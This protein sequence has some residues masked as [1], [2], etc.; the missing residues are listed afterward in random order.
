M[1]LDSTT[2]EVADNFIKVYSSIEGSFYVFAPNG[3]DGWIHQKRTAPRNVEI[4]IYEG[5]TTKDVNRHHY[6]GIKVAVNK[7]LQADASYRPFTRPCYSAS[8]K[9]NGPATS[10]GNNLLKST[11]SLAGAV[12]SSSS[13]LNR[14]EVLQ[15]ATH[16][17]TSRVF[18][19]RTPSLETD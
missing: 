2:T 9:L 18:E 1:F 10:P 14:E 17:F 5:S 8:S 6:M 16:L 7:K 3:S 19:R 4:A 12:S 13:F 15:R 11:A